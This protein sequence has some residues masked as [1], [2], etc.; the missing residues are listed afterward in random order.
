[1][2]VN[3]PAEVCQDISSYFASPES[4][5]DI[6]SKFQSFDYVSE[7]LAT[8]T[9]EETWNTNLIPIAGDS[10]STESVAT[11]SSPYC[12]VE[13]AHPCE[14]DIELPLPSFRREVS[15]VGQNQGFVL[16]S[17]DE[18]EDKQ[19]PSV[20]D[21]EE[22]VMDLDYEKRDHIQTFSNGLNFDDFRV[23]V[24]SSN[25]LGAIPM[26]PVN[27]ATAQFQSLGVHSPNPKPSESPFS[28]P[29]PPIDLSSC[30]K[31]EPNTTNSDSPL[32]LPSPEPSPENP[33]S[34]CFQFREHTQLNQSPS[35][36]PEIDQSFFDFDCDYA[37]IEDEYTKVK[38]SWFSDADSCP[39][40]P[41]FELEAP[42][43]PPLETSS[44]PSSPTC[45]TD[46]DDEDDKIIIGSYT[47]AQRRKKIERFKQK[48]LKRSF[49]KK[50]MYKCRKQFADNRPR[51]G[52]RFIKMKKPDE[53]GK[54]AT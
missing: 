38:D 34:K 5:S 45:K 15:F 32:V 14:Q 27:M 16:F 44:V 40:S 35:I 51:V 20:S 50:I 6:N 41:N 48:R 49:T 26:C 17:P 31:S 22:D 3:L 39:S 13:P 37:K 21:T 36:K 10:I 47:R 43:V 53:P 8:K 30:V 11:F 7:P 12:K 4:V 28:L 9:L 33:L 25:P 24:T 46:E 19:L 29:L 42:S 52:G 23:G 2:P 18:W 1:M 54:V